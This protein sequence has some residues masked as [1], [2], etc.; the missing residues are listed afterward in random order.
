MGGSKQL[1][2]RSKPKIIKLAF[3]DGKI[4]KPTVKDGE[5]LTEANAWEIVNSMITSWIMDVIDPKLHASVAY[6]DSA[7][8]MWENI[9]KRYSTPNVPRIDQLYPK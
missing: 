5:Y 9:W 7:Q 4:T 8:T 3:I 2:T 1:E 6:V